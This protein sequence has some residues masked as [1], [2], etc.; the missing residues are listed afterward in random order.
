M[1]ILIDIGHP[2]HVHYFKNFAWIMQKKGNDI[3]FTC[4][5][6][7]F[8]IDLLEK[9]GFNF[10]S[11]GKHY[12]SIQGKAFGLLKFNLKLFRIA[13]KFKPDLFLSAGSMYAA[14]ISSLVGK[15]HITLE[16]TGNMEQIRLYRPFTKI[17]LTPD[18]LPKKFG[19]KQVSYNGFHQSAY[20][21]PNYFSIN[22]DYKKEL[23][24]NSKEKIFLLRLVALN[25]THDINLKNISSENL[26]SLVN[27]LNERGKLFISSE[28]PLK[29]EL[30]KF[31]LNIPSNRIHDFISICDLVVGESG[32]MTNEAAYMGVPNVL[33]GY[34]D[35]DVHKKYSKLGL[36]IHYKEMNQEVMDK[37]KLVVDD[38]DEI[39]RSFK[40]KSNRYIENSIDLTA[41]IIKLVH[42]TVNRN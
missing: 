16:D 25:S 5:D 1:K 28:K 41:F 21:H 32:A 9:G 2:A 18:A 27:F 4:R 33:I 13:L 22:A 7:E 39:K 11:L 42:S 24:I 20:L 12:K 40:D 35:F 23:G 36:K 29:K 38:L 6:K 3:L 30:E 31:K 17:I 14:Q 15:P 34:P 19:E 26:M 8:E 37:I 10:K